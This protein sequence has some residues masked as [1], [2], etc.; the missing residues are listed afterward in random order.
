LNSNSSQESMSHVLLGLKTQIAGVET[1][2]HE[3]LRS[4]YTAPEL[5]AD[6][7]RMT[8]NLRNLIREAESLHSSAST[9]VGNTRS[10]VWGGSVL[11]DPL[12]EEQYSSI[13]NWIPPPAIEEESVDVKEGSGDAFLDS[14]LGDELD[15]GIDSDA[16]S[17]IERHLARRYRDIALSSFK[18]K[19]YPRAESFYRKVIEMNSDS[20]LPTDEL[21]GLNIMLAFSC[22][23]QGK[24]EESETIFPPL[25]FTKGIPDI[26]PFHGLYALS[27]VHFSNGDYETATKYCKRAVGGY[28]RLLGK[29]DPRYFNSMHTLAFI[30]DSKDDSVSAEGCRTFFPGSLAPVDL[31]PQIFLDTVLSSEPNSNEEQNQ[32]PSTTLSGPSGALL[33]QH[34]INSQASTSS[35]IFQSL[36]GTLTSSVEA[37]NRKMDEQTLEPRSLSSDQMDTA[38]KVDGPSHDRYARDNLTYQSPLLTGRSIS[39]GEY[40][41]PV[42]WFEPSSQAEKR[43]RLVVAV[44]FGMTHTSVA[45]AL[46]G[47][48][49][50]REGLLTNWPRTSSSTDPSVGF[51]RL[52]RSHQITKGSLSRMYFITISN[53]SW[54]VG[55]WILLT[56]FNSL[57]FPRRGPFPSTRRWNG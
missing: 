52:S 16:D 3:Q 30:Y 26:R 9:I 12:S 33:S 19:D 45:W 28:R 46:V 5:A 38:N 53:K 18:K 51:P 48:E 34:D 42:P 36:S 54:L 4:G 13:R 55:V 21:Q 56:R 23:L 6:S 29:L 41:S 2:L 37:I 10:T 57:T 43:S 11:G 50:V 1:A 47:T 39:A 22:G 31:N 40:N 32:S 27:M 14:A 49:G 8:R 20:D 7:D 17:D 25:A 24:W 44:D 15:S 35:T